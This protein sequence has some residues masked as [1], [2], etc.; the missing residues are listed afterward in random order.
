M[1]ECKFCKL[2][3]ASD[4]TRVGS[5]YYIEDGYPVTPGHTLIIPV[6]HRADYFELSS[7]ELN[8]T[9][10]AIWQIRKNLLSKG[11]Q[12][13]NIGWNCGIVAGQ[14]IGHAHCHVIPRRSGDM[15]DPTGGVRGVIPSKQK[16]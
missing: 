4:A 5:V 3:N 2:V 14:T 9:N 16:Y 10:A 7:T 6:N 8:D 1:S 15:S 12:G 11:A 13:F